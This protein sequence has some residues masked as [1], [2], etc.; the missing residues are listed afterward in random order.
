LFR[1]M[2]CFLGFLLFFLSTPRYSGSSLT[3]R[4]LT[5]PE[6]WSQGLTLYLLSE[7]S[8]PVGHRVAALGL[9]AFVPGAVVGLFYFLKWM[10]L[11]FFAFGWVIALELIT[12]KELWQISPMGKVV[13]VA[14][15]LF[16]CY[17]CAQ[18]L[19]LG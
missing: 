10:G 19:R 8:D 14:I 3:Y 9:L 18:L 11:P 1:L 13:F 4:D 6:H 7:I 16:N 12:D 17:T 5:A 15:N 2:Y